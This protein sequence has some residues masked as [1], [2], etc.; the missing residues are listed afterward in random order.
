MK[1]KTIIING[2][3]LSV[4]EARR[5]RDKLARAFALG[6]FTQERHREHWRQW[7]V[8]VAKLREINEY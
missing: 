7:E 8:L 5:T 3:E 2:K 4:A 1:P 6:A